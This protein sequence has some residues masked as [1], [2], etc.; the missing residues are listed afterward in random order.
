V[1][2]QHIRIFRLSLTKRWQTL[3]GIIGCGQHQ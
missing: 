2:A 1:T 3:I